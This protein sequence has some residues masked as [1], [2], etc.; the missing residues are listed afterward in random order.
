VVYANQFGEETLATL[1]GTVLPTGDLRLSQESSL[2][3][4]SGPNAGQRVELDEQLIIGRGETCGMRL[5]DPDI[6]REHARVTRNRDGA[7]LLEDLRSRNGTMVDAVPVTRHMLRVGDRIRFGRSTVVLFTNFG[8]VED[9]ILHKQ[10]LEA[11]GRLAGGVA[12]D[13]NNLLGAVL[14]NVAYLLE[15]QGELEAGEVTATLDDIQSAA[16]RAADLTR[17]LLGFARKGKYEHRPTNV[18]ELVGEVVNILG[19]T[20]DPAVRFHVNGD[21]S[22]WVLGDR[23]QLHQVFLNLCINARDAMPHGGNLRID[24]FCRDDFVIVEFTDD[25]CGMPPDVRE[26][27]FEPFFTTKDVGRGTGL[28]LATVYGVVKNHGGEIHVESEVGRGTTFRIFLPRHETPEPKTEVVEMTSPGVEQTVLVVDDE[29]L[30]RRGCARNLRS[31]GFKVLTAEDGPEAIRLY[32]EH[33]D[34]IDVVLLD[35]LMPGM[36]GEQVAERLYAMDPH[37]RIVA[38]SG[39]ADM[40]DADLLFQ[41]R[42]VGFLRKPFTPVGLNDTIMRALRKPMSRR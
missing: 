28:G 15:E 40:R 37:V 34:H 20:I 26:R 10:K 23:S 16:L 6:S 14:S 29:Q 31:G 24:T 2:I 5:L 32:E 4:L 18:H 21:P 38:I 41:G 25:G 3:V 27:V 8:D 12:H 39:F 30:A 19:R 35:V 11:L 7:Y 1:P 36:S 13:F 9:Q 22:L 42:S 17:Q 33:K